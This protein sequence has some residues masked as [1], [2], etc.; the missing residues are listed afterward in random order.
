MSLAPIGIGTYSRINHLKQTVESLQENTLANQSELY[1]FID[2]PKKGDEIIVQ[3][4]IDYSESVTGFKKVH[5][6]KREK[7]MFPMNNRN[8]ISQLLD[9]YGKAIFMED[10]NVCAPGFLQFI[11]DALDFYED[12]ESI[13]SIGGY[14][15][16]IRDIDDYDKDY[17]IFKRF[18]GWGF[19]TW[20]NKW[21]WSQFE[22][23]KDIYKNQMSMLKK[24]SGRGF[25]IILL[26]SK[27]QLNAHDSR[28]AIYMLMNNKYMITPSKSLVQNI[29]ND[30]SGQH[31]LKTTNYEVELW[32]KLAGFKFDK[33]IE[34]DERVSQ[35]YL[36]FNKE[37]LTDM[38]VRIAIK[39]NTYFFF[40]KLYQ[41]IF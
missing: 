26:N 7:N 3:K 10:D 33:I 15:F 37:S 36:E 2:G 13:I 24:E 30:G 14:K 21:D 25:N 28:V 4:V 20:K 8:G 29:G 11:N 9:D 1:I 19:A 22:F 40:R 39:T 32:D 6:I 27:K 23:E 41:K 17:M 18:N 38:L 34:L 35:A 5:V 16:P 31:S 12:D